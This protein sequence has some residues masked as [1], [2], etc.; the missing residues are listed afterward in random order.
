ML[1]VALFS[2]HTH[3][4]SVEAAAASWKLLLNLSSFTYENIFPLSR[5]VGTKSRLHTMCIRLFSLLLVASLYA[6]LSLSL[7]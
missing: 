2:A 4:Q 7:V 6:P 5:S 3:T 1:R